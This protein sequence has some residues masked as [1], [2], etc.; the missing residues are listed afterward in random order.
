[1]EEFSEMNQQGAVVLC[2]GEPMLSLHRYFEILRQARAHGLRSLSVIN[3]TRIRGMAMARRMLAEGP[4]EIS[5]SLNSHRA[6]LH[7]RTR[8]VEGSFAKAVAALRL[9]L[10][11]RDEVPGSRTRIYVMGLVFDENYREL[12]AFY[13]FVLNDVGADKLKLNF[14]QPSF[15]QHDESDAF[16]ESHARIDPEALVAEIARCD[17]RFAL[18][19]NPLWLSQVAMYFRSLA[20]AGDLGRGWGA[21]ASTT[22]HI[23]NTYDR[24]I[25]I[26][27]YG[28]ARLCFAGDYR[29][30]KIERY[31]DLRRFW[32]TSHDIAD[33]MRGC[34]RLCGIS[35]SVRRETSTVASRAA[36]QVIEPPGRLARLRERI[37]QF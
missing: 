7:D 15:G 1:M 11:A 26:D 27:H 20:G 19:L 23:C 34:N 25:M 35:H 33:A 29:G 8:G 9:L 12:E 32:D 21:G 18:K 16:F 36:T 3:G 14:L 13:D 6:D 31:G 4:D 2:G 5:I 37:S 28:M 22:E 24:N 17:A 10:A 30:A